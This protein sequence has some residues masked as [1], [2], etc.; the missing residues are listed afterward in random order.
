MYLSKPWTCSSNDAIPT[1]AMNS[2]SPTTMSP[3]GPLLAGR[4]P[5]VRRLRKASSPPRTRTTRLSGP[6]LSFLYSRTKGSMGNP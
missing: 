5:P 3:A 6:P 4:V 1:V 2:S